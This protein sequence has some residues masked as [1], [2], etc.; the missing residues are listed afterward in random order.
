M[1]LIMNA[2]LD[3]HIL[4]FKTNVTDPVQVDSLANTLDGINN[5]KEWNVDWEDCDH[6]LRVVCD[7]LAPAEVVNQM[8]RLGFNCE[9][10]E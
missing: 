5:I 4:V 9:E 2:P 8:Q 3:Q 7:C 6:V 1:S 10:L